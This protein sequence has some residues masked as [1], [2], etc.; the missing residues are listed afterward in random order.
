MGKNIIR[1]TENKDKFSVSSSS[2][3]A[4]HQNVFSEMQDEFDTDLD[5]D[6]EADFDLEIPDGMADRIMAG[7]VLS[8]ELEGKHVP[9]RI[10]RAADEAVER[11][12]GRRIVPFTR[13]AIRN[14]GKY[15]ASIAACLVLAIGMLTMSDPSGLRIIGVGDEPASSVVSEEQTGSSGSAASEPG[16]VQ[17]GDSQQSETAAGSQQPASSSG[18][19][20]GSQNNA[21]DSSSG[22]SSVS[23][24]SS[25]GGSSSSVS[26]GSESS[27]NSGSSSD[28]SSDSSESQSSTS[29]NQNDSTSSDT[30][31]SSS[32]DSNQSSDD[33]DIMD[34][35]AVRTVSSVSELQE[36]MNYQPPVPA[37]QQGWSISSIEVIYGETAQITYTDG[38]SSV[39]YRTAAG[40]R[41]LNAGTSY[42]SSETTDGITYEG[43][44]DGTVY[45]V[46]WKDSE[47]SYSLVFNS[48]T[49]REEALSWVSSVS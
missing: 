42:E 2:D 14:F 19:A 11:L 16:N 13:A 12:S 31:D 46:S 8:E 24:P 4:G 26:S 49:S 44:S 10:E 20:S 1:E 41:E 18:T 15:A 40:D 47:N 38:N 22:G 6:L 32:T 21:S 43:S 9:D 33:S 23:T 36:Y 28:D 25:A 17:T 30:S 5:F 3:S 29:E 34:N 27:K 48:G 35:D 37:V 45:L 7:A 39:I